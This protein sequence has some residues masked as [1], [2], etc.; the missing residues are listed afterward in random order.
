MRPCDGVHVFTT[1]AI[2]PFH[3][4]PLRELDDVSPAERFHGHIFDT[5]LVWSD[6][7]MEC[8]KLVMSVFGAA[9]GF[10][11]DIDWANMYNFV[12]DAD[13]RGAVRVRT[14]R[15]SDMA[16]SLASRVAAKSNPICM[17]SV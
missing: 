12:D 16:V 9:N 13:S 7:V 17:N 10:Q 8:T 15:S 2:F 14:V 6:A 3:V 4:L 1:D 5:A 11:C